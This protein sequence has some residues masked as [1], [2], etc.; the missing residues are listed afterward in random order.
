MT[1]QDDAPAELTADEIASVSGGNS[2]LI[3]SGGG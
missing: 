1:E 3:W 2:G